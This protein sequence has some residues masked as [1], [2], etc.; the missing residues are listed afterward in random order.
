MMGQ[1]FRL[2]LGD[3]GEKPLQRRGGATVEFLPPSPQQRAVGGILHQGMFEH[4]RI[5]AG[6]GPGRTAIPGVVE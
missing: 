2:A 1:K 6:G 3:F 5:V 4:I